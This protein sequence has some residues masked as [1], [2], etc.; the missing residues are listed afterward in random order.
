MRKA[1]CCLCR[2]GMLI[3]NIISFKN[4]I[5]EATKTIEDNTSLFYQQKNKEAYE[6]LDSTLTLLIST[7]NEILELKNENKELNIDEF[8][9]NTVLESSMKAIE[10]G[11]TILLSDILFFDLKPLLE[12]IID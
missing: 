4:M 11:D 7:I 1:L 6:M 5:L 2:E 3:M 12:Q 10:A 8:E 9:I